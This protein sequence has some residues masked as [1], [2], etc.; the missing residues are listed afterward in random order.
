MIP[1]VAIGLGLGIGFRLARPVL[2]I[3]AFAVVLATIILV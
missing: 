2:W 1:G 3:A